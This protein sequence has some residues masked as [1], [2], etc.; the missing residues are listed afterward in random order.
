MRDAGVSSVIE[1]HGP[2]GWEMSVQLPLLIFWAHNL[3]HKVKLSKEILRWEFPSKD[4]NDK[5]NFAFI[6]LTNDLCIVICIAFSLLRP[7]WRAACTRLLACPLSQCDIKPIFWS[8]HV[9][10]SH[11]FPPSHPFSQN[12]GSMLRIKPSAHA[13]RS[14]Q[15]A[16][17]LEKLTFLQAAEALVTYF[18]S[19]GA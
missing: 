4:C 13:A 1:A 3:A 19:P 7:W 11:I 6:S 5:I 17:N 12:Q 15:S 9:V 18:A 2:W 16:I 8:W 14:E 10:R